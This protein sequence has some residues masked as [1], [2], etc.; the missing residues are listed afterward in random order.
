MVKKELVILIKPTV[1][2]S[3]GDWT[4]D[5]RETRERIVNPVNRGESASPA[6]AR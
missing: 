6:A 4:E 5:L 2:R 1:I 3:D